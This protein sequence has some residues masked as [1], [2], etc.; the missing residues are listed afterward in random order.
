[1]EGHR[2]ALGHRH[3]HVDLGSVGRE[4][5][6]EQIGRAAGD[7]AAGQFGAE[8]GTGV[9]EIGGRGGAVP[10]LQER[11]DSRLVRPKPGHVAPLAPL[12][13]EFPVELVGVAVDPGVGPGV[14]KVDPL[15]VRRHV[16]G[17]AVGQAGFAKDEVRHEPQDRGAEGVGLGLTVDGR[18]GG[19]AG[20]ADPVGAVDDRHLGAG[21]AEVVRGDE[22]VD[23]GADHG[24]LRWRRQRPHRT[25]LCRS[26]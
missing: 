22:A 24:H 20:A 1:M 21:A 5:V 13:R 26:R 12:R 23:A 8:A 19:D 14:G 2:S 16:G 3:P 6:I 17:E 7:P 9:L 11:D 15:G 4:V 18:G 10:L 25:P